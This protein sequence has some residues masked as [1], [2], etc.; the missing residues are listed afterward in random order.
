[1]IA[2]G[3]KSQWSIWYLGVSLEHR[4]HVSWECKGIGLTSYMICICLDDPTSIHIFGFRL[5]GT[6]ALRV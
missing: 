6:F 3:P 5:T 4:L 2:R 1:M